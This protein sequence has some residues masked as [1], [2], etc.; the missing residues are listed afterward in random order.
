M[1]K[2]TINV[3]ILGLHL[4]IKTTQS[5]A[6]VDRVVKTLRGRIDEIQKG[7]LAVDSLRVA[8][9]AALDLARELVAVKAELDELKDF[10]SERTLAL[11]ERLEAETAVETMSEP[12]LPRQKSSLV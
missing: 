1:E 6:E 12:D 4:P 2:R 7:S 11:V 9:L 5:P 8:V 10:T 3:E